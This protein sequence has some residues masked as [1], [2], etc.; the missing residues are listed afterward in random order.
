[1]NTTNELQNL[2][3]SNDRQQHQFQQSS[4]KQSRLYWLKTYLALM[5]GVMANK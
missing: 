3:S 4:L 2:A 1:M 5:N